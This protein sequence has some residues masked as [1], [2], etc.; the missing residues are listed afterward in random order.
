MITPRQKTNAERPKTVEKNYIKNK[1]QIVVYCHTWLCHNWALS[2]KDER[3]W[4]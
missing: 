3:R 2:D 1:I 4:I